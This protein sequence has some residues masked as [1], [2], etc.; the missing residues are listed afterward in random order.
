MQFFKSI[1]AGIAMFLT[2]APLHA[3]EQI[4]VQVAAPYVDMH[5]GP[6]S[7]YPKFYV[8]EK[9][10]WITVVGRRTGYFKVI[11]ADGTG[12]WVSDANMAKTV[13]SQGNAVVITSGGIKGIL[14]KFK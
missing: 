5:S 7:D 12:G 3:A 8:A 13:D 11:S 10:E 1:V 2:L 6:S 14:E 9:G 4:K